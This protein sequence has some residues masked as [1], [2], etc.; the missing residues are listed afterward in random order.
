MKKLISSLALSVLLANQAF[1]ADDPVSIMN[2]SFLASKVTDSVANSKFRLFNASGQERVRET[3]GSTKLIDGTSDNRRLVNFESPADVKGTKTLLIEHSKGDDDIWIYL[4]AMK[5]VRRL[6]S[7]NKKDSFV[8]T[9]FSYGDV[10]GHKV[11]DWN[12]KILREEKIDGRDTWVIESTPKSPEVAENT[13]YSKRLSWVDKESRITLK[14]ESFDTQGQAFKQFSAKN[15]QKVDEKN[16][17][18]QPM[19]LEA[20]NLQT[21]TRTVLE[22]SDYKANVGVKDEIFTS[23]SLEKN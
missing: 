1:A 4:P 19:I 20:K 10:I 14:G 15:V 22:F 13:G 23:R 9:D 16:N 6:V 3:K 7:S 21:G 12:H 2:T 18:W 11:E 5:K 8:G 17:K